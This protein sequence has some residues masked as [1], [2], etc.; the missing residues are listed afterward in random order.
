MV[1]AAQTAPSQMEAAVLADTATSFAQTANPMMQQLYAAWHPDQGPMAGTAGGSAAGAGSAVA[2]SGSAPASNVP[3]HQVAA[4]DNSA[5]LSVPNG[6]TVDPNSSRGAII[7]RGPNGEQMGLEMNRGGIDPTNAFRARSDARG[8]LEGPGTVVYAF[9]GDLT[10]EFVNVFQAWRKAG[11]QG[12]AKIQVDTIQQMPSS[13]GI[14]TVTATGQIDPDGKGMQ[15][16]TDMLTVSD[17][18]RDYGSY[19]VTLCHTMLPLAIADKEKPMLTSIIKTY[20]PNMQVVNGENAQLLQKKQQSDQQ[21]LQNGQM[22]SNQIRQQGQAAQ[23]R[24]NATEAANDAQHAGYWAQQN[25]NA[26][27]SAGFSNYLLDQSVVQNNN[28]GGMGAVGHATVWNTQANAM[29]Q[30]N[31]N[32]YEIVNTPNYWQGVDY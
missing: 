18:T 10:K 16:F 4:P 13:Q 8:Q 11:G 19:S 25:T 31:P 21:I 14:H 28:V 30:A 3:L 24:F 17:P 32:K 5:S 20:Q 26:K 29:V 2:S 7:V 6:W 15:Y 12:P 23:A 22:I 9:R 27:Q 1:I